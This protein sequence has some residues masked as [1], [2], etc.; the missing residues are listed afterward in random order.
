MI[1]DMLLVR[2]CLDLSG[3]SYTV[4][5]PMAFFICFNGSDHCPAKVNGLIIFQCDATSK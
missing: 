1:P 2:F 3:V 5:L 4:L